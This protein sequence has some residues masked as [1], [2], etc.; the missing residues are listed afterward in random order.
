MWTERLGAGERE[1]R[2]SPSRKAV[3][4]EVKGIREP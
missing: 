2:G 1:K 3:V 4:L